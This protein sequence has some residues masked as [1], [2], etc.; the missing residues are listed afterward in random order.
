MPGKYLKGAFIQMMPTILVPLPNVIIF[1]YNP[2]T[3]THTW[4]PAARDT[5]A[6]PGG[7]QP[8][9]LAVKGLPGE[10]F[11]FNLAMDAS[12]MIADGSPV[13]VGLATATG[14]YSRL[15][16]LEMLLYPTGSFSGGSLLGTV[17]AG[18]GGVAAAIG[19]STGTQADRSVPQSTLPTVL[20]VWG[21][22]RILPVKVTTLTITEK[23]YDALLL[24][25]THAEAQIGI[26]VL[27]PDEIVAIQDSL[28][29]VAQ[30][31][32]EYSQGLR[33]ALALANLANAAESIIGMLPIG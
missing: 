12:D 13:A 33:Q 23:L 21:P 17:S 9:P 14:I 18:A 22:G 8:N 16:A 1:Q 20:F 10:S 24:N 6:T 4:T 15:A 28:Q 26:T 27:T 31:A 2:E 7:G 29:Q 11:S 19:G 3:M 25:P 5:T 30:T 32:Y